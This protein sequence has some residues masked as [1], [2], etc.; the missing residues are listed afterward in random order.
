MFLKNSLC[1]GILTKKYRE[2]HKNA[3]FV[4]FDPPNDIFKQSRQLTP[5]LKFFLRIFKIFFF[6]KIFTKFRLM[7]YFG[8][9]NESILTISTKNELFWLKMSYSDVFNHFNDILG[10]YGGPQTCIVLLK[11]C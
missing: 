5:P 11:Y 6:W 10:Q 4:D 8:P 3:Y 9:K 1:I 2:T 7:T